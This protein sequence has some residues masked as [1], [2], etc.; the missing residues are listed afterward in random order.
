MLEIVHAASV[1]WQ[2][3]MPQRQKG[4]L[5][6]VHLKILLASADRMVTF[7]RYDPGLVVAPHRHE[8]VEMIYV[9]EGSMKIDG[10]ACIPGTLVVLDGESTIGPIVSGESGTVLLE[11]FEGANSWNPRLLEPTESYRRLV[12]ERDITELPG[13][14]RGDHPRPGRH[15]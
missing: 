4:K 6:A 1:P 2:D 8:G 9:L 14:G 11:V 5:L 7:T 10:A 12:A 15:S 3:A 13:A